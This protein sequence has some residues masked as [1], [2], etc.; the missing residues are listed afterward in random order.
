MAINGVLNFKDKNG[1]VTTVYPVTSAENVAGI[2]A[3]LA[4]KV[5]KEAGKGLSTNDYTIAEK[6]KLAGIEAGANAYTLPAATSSTLGGVKQG[7]NIEIA[8]DGT[9]S[10][11]D[12]I[13][14]AAT[15]STDGLMS[16]ADKTKLEGIA[17]GA[18]AVHVDS[19]LS[20]TST[21]PV[22]NKVV[23]S[24]VSGKVDKVTGKGLSTN[25]FTNAE[26][27]KLSGIA[28]GAE[29]NVQADWNQTTST[30]D[31]YIKNKPA[32]GS[33][34]A[35]S[36]SDF[37]T[38]A[39]G[40]KADSAIPSSAK[41]TANGVAELDSNGLVPASQLPSFVD[42]V[43]EYASVSG[44]PE[45]GETGKI[46]VD[47][48][49]NKIYRWSG[50]TYVEISSSLALG[51]TSSTAFRGD[52]GQTAYEHAT[53]ASRLTTAKTSGLY[54]IAATAE[55]HVASVT[56]VT[57]SDITALGIP[58][59]DTTYSEATT[60]AS[61]LMSASDKSKLNGIEAQAN[62]TVV[63]D[64]LSS[65]STNPVQNKAVKAALDE[66]NSSLVNGLA[67]KADASTVTSLSGRVTQAE[68]D[69]D[70]L[71]S[72]ID[73]IIALPEGS[74]TG[75]AELMD[76]RLKADGT[77]ASS[78]GTAVREQVD[79][80][81]FDINSVVPAF[82]ERHFTLH[83]GYNFVKFPIYA[84][85]RY[86]IV[87]NTSS[88]IAV[89]T[90]MSIDGSDIEILTNDLSANDEV[91]KRI[92]ADA[93]LMRIYANGTGTVTLIDLDSEI[94][95]LDSQLEGVTY[96]GNSRKDLNVIHNLFTTDVINN[97]KEHYYIQYDDGKEH[98]M[99]EYCY[100]PDHIA[101]LPNKK[102]YTDV[103]AHVCFYDKDKNFISGT[104]TLQASYGTD[105]TTPTN[106]C[107]VIMSFPI[108]R[109]NSSG[110]PR[111]M[112]ESD[113]PELFKNN[114]W[115]NR[116]FKLFDSDGLND[117]F[118]GARN[119][120]SGYAL[121]RRLLSMAPINLS[122]IKYEDGYYF[123]A[124]T[125]RKTILESYFVTQ[126]IAVYPNRH[127]M[128][129]SSPAHCTFWD[130]NDT[131]I[132]GVVVNQTYDQQ[133]YGSD[134]TTPNNCRYLRIS[135]S[136]ESR[137]NDI[138]SDLSSPTKHTN[139]YKFVV[140][141]DGTGNYT[142]VADAVEA[143]DSDDFIF[144]KSGEY[145]EVIDLPENK[146]VHLVG[147][148]RCNTI[149]YN[150]YGDYF[151]APLTMGG[152]S[153]EELTIYSKKVEGVTPAE[154]VSYGIHVE[155]HSL[156]NNSLL[157]KN[158]I[159]KSDYS[160]ALGM[161]MR[162]GCEIIIE[163]C[164]FI[165]GSD[166]AALYFHDSDY[167]AYVGDQ[168]ITVRNCRLQCKGNPLGILFLQ[169]QNKSDVYVTFQNNFIRTKQGVNNIRTLNWYG[170]ESTDPD[171]FLHLYRWR[172]TDMSYGNN[173]SDLNAQ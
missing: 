79:D 173:V 33:A 161:G 68:T 158:C 40:T 163:N 83:Q 100:N 93:N 9:I 98:S 76:I 109:I 44:F 103:P 168:H 167:D 87:N 126:P 66:Q 27:S 124:N 127:Y 11:T 92:S 5:D 20:N 6:T 113:F 10:A 84:G 165:H 171:D 21:N 101:V 64:A 28:E 70:T 69:I 51:T 138:L 147:E 62:K 136:I 1:D 133:T 104:L 74:T 63:D 152:G 142:S 151:R 122:Q 46:Y 31:D 107:Y 78:A 75:D 16:A 67:T 18:T 117:L 88:S 102:Y 121:G 170:G 80:L 169:S 61:G 129:S 30:A 141:K 56:P 81:Q 29:V 145:D 17:S 52:R 14:E 135:A 89:A 144:I 59:Q 164:D 96:L 149:I 172:L 106:A 45:T 54:K 50:S 153:L 120:V 4:G 110:H 38:A 137:N 125:G 114:I 47:K 131:F 8:E 123:D 41:G 72:R 34:A 116:D 139:K 146:R 150:T 7:E 55:G 23:Y 118:I 73:A 128:F 154:H 119:T 82:M 32:L 157:L 58:A 37:A 155:K 49:D 115:M 112:E 25:D 156:Y 130:E 105:F 53:D 43:L 65:S 77:T 12:T 42:D 143:A 166:S 95:I 57:K 134:F 85:R 26:K 48:S 132:S 86:K 2:S 39:Q 71:D 111:L 60:S 90:R 162:G 15:P 3:A 160:A 148:N 140:A 13:Y 159:V 35:A 99:D 91:V 97:L 24:A 36:A 22:Q 94:E 108:S 19:E